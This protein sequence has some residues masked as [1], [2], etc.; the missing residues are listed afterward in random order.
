METEFEALLT[1]VKPTTPLL[2][3]AKTM[4]RSQWDYQADTDR[5]NKISLESELK[6]TQTKIARLL[7][8]VINSDS[9]T[10][11]AAYEEKIKQFEADKILLGEK[12]ARC[13]SVLPDYD[14]TFRTAFVFLEN[15]QKL[16]ASER[17]ADKR[18]TLK[19]VFAQNLEYVRREG[20]RTASFSLPFKVLQE[21]KRYDYHMA[22]REGFEPSEGINPRWFSRPVHS[23]ALPPL[24]NSLLY[25]P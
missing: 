5:Q 4:F 13:G 23:T 16:W 3:M 14:E 1:S 7:D 10:L 15:P 11:I 6:Q 22:E 2:N 17:L 21:M 8:R 12:L 25:T 9:P 20:F 18:T 24:R 19:L